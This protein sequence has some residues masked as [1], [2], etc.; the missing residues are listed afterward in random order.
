MPTKTLNPFTIVAFF[1]FTGLAAYGFGIPE[2]VTAGIVLVFFTIVTFINPF[3]AIVFLLLSTPFFLGE[4][5]WPYYW[6]TEALVFITILSALIHFS[7]KKERIE[8]PLKYPLALLLVSSICSIPIDG[9]EFYYD[10]WASS[11]GDM[12]SWWITAHPKPKL[13]YLR[14]LTNMASAMALFLISF[15]AVRRYGFDTILS[16]FKAV[17]IVCGGVSVVGIMLA[18]KVIP[19]NPEVWRYMTLSLVGDYFGSITV[20]AFALHFLGQYLLLVLPV[21]LYFMYVNFHRPAS[22]A[23]YV[24]I[25]ALIS[26]CVIQGGLRGAALLLYIT[27]FIAFAAYVYHLAGSRK[28]GKMIFSTAAIILVAIASGYLLTKGV[29]SQRFAI[30]ILDKINSDTIT[31]IPNF[32]N[33]PLFFW[34]RGIMEPR[35]FLWHTAVL[36]FFSSPLLGVG[37]GRFTTLFREYFAS[38]WYTWEDIGF[39]ANASAHS[40]YFETLANQG[41]IGFLLW[42]LLIGVV[43]Y[44]AVRAIRRE[45]SHQKKIFYI[46]ILSSIIIWL[47]IGVI[48]HVTLGRIIEIYFWISLGILA[49]YSWDEIKT[50]ELGKNKAI[51]ALVIIAAAFCYQISLVMARPVPKD[52]Q[53]GFSSW[54]KKPDG[55]Y[56]RW[57]GKRAVYSAMAEDGEVSLSLVV[58]LDG[59]EKKPQRVKVWVGDS[60]KEIVI[61][62]RG[63]FTARFPVKSK[64]GRYLVW[65]EADHTY[66]PVKNRISRQRGPVG[67][68]IMKPRE[69]K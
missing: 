63:L 60:V 46:A 67:V 8:I 12:Y 44:G 16:T 62:N 59:L 13:H 31:G 3:N 65:I 42:G 49:G 55:N 32:I 26:F 37:L 7:K 64:E 52:F 23:L 53:T 14:I 22:L 18:Y 1:L 25:F 2:S 9:K 50:V 58:T 69:N 66:D 57:M 21:T 48:H 51:I 24:A 61:N 35:F 29:A 34:S 6:M 5:S 20:F 47:A 45:S 19:T 38:D 40:F 41:I 15:H 68:M 54:E 39:A 30:E 43:I 36:M 10:Y 27:V 4:S 56:Y 33:D 28:R 11:F 17:V